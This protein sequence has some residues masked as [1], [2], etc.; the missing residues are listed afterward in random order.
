[1]KRI[2]FN[3]WF[4]TAF[5]LIKMMRENEDITVIGTNK[6]R[7]VAYSTVCDEFYSEPDNIGEEEYIDFCLEFCREK[8]IDIFVPRRNLLAIVRNSE[9]FENIGVKLFAD[10]NAT[11]VET[12]EDKGKTYQYFCSAFPRMI[13]PYRVVSSIEDFLVA[14]RQIENECDRVCYKLTKDEGARS[15]RVIDETIESPNALYEKPG[16]KITLRS[17]LKVLGGYDF[18]V[19]VLLMPYLDGVEISVDCLAMKGENLIIP[20]FKTSK[21]YS[22]VKFPPDLINE[23]NQITDFLHLSFPF[24]IQYKLHEGKRYLL[25]INTRMSGGLQLSWAATGINLPYLALK[26]LL[27][28]ETEVSFSRI[29]RKVVHIETPIML[30]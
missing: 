21:R 19:P 24:N 27:G 3:H 5:H 26:K 25:E 17:A 22:E 15:F 12:L 18:S 28:A 1:M 23:C 6:N 20:R 10:K 11:L 16:A 13:P 30:S 29:E 14:Y 7:V 2:W 4:S 8:A 9:K